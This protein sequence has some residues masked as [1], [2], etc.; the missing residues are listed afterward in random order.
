MALQDYSPLLDS[1][2][3]SSQSTLDMYKEAFDTP[4]AQMKRELLRSMFG[5]KDEEDESKK[6]QQNTHS[7]PQP[8]DTAEFSQAS[9][10]LSRTESAS[11][12]ASNENGTLEITVTHTESLN[13][14]ASFSPGENVQQSDPLVLDLNGD[15]INLTHVENGVKFD[16][17]GNG[18][19]E[20]VAWVASSDGLLVWD[21][22][23]NGIIDNGKELFGD[24][25]GAVDG[26]M[27]LTTL[28][29]DKNGT[30]DARDSLFEKLNIWQDKNQNGIS[31]SDEL[32]N[33]RAL[34]I[35]AISLWTT[36]AN[37]VNAGNLI[38]AYGSF[39]KT[40]GTGIVGEAFLNYLA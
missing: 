27:E 24:Q 12:S 32:Q 25:H 40:S 35:N 10:A 1:Q 9:L 29:S 4:E 22:N 37:D 14:Q 15:G 16:I 28:D 33:L 20:Q 2:T 34:G 5:M 11:F 23:A 17:T 18:T 39:S 21:R 31:E 36:S 8:I 19:K 3:E 6:K 26:F 30:I 38:S 7:T 13:I